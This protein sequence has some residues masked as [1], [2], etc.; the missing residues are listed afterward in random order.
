MPKRFFFERVGA[1]LSPRC[2][3]GRIDPLGLAG[4]LAQ[5]GARTATGALPRRMA[6]LSFEMA[7]VAV[8]RSTI[9]PEPKDWRFEN[10]AWKENPLY[11]R[12]CQAYL[13]WSRTAL[14][15]VDDAHLEWRTEERAKLATILVTAAL[16][17]TNVPPLN[18]D[19]VE[20]G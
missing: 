14:D 10:R 8:G 19:V 11:R 16:A 18:P 7:K 15:L 4:S 2:M 13:A 9:A 3:L 20:R 6:G 5:V 17:P 12:V 1:A